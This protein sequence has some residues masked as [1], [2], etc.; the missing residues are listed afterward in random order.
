[1]RNVDGGQTHSVEQDG[2][3]PSSLAGDKRLSEHFM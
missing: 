3:I 2:F 1:M